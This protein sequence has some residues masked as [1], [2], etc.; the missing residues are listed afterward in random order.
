MLSPPVQSVGSEAD[1]AAPA[2]QM[3]GPVEL[4]VAPA[5]V[6]GVWQAVPSQYWVP[7]V[8]VPAVS[9][10][11]HVAVLQRPVVSSQVIPVAHGVSGF[12]HPVPASVAAAGR[13][14]TLFTQVRACPLN[15]LQSESCEQ[16]GSQRRSTGLQ[17]AVA[18]HEAVEP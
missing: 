14:Q 11:P 10:V 4:A 16:S 13:V 17:I 12:W 3:N 18:P 15:P 1:V 7:A 9:A 2:D 8:Q 6:A 5:Q